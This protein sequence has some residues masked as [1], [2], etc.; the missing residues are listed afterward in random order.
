MNEKEKFSPYSYAHVAMMTG[1]SRI[2]E[3]DVNKST[4][5]SLM[6]PGWLR[7]VLYGDLDLARKTDSEILARIN[8]LIAMYES[9]FLGFLSMG[10]PSVVTHQ[11]LAEKERTLKVA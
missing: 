11:S 2:D 6:T 8:T 4:K 7:R 3:R 5:I 1:Y 9:E 10:K